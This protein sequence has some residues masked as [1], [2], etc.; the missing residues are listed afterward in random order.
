MAKL[1]IDTM[2]D[3][4]EI[5]HYDTPGIPLYIRKGNL[6]DYPGRR[7]PCHWH[8]DI[9][10]ILLLDGEMNYYVNGENIELG[11]GEGIFVNSRVM[12]Y[13]YAARNENCSFLC[14]LFH[15]SLL[16]S[17]KQVFQ[18]YVEPIL[19]ETRVSYLYISGQGQEEMENQILN[20]WK[21]KEMQ[22]PCYEM[23]VIGALYS[24]WHSVSSMITQMT[25]S[26]EGEPSADVT[27]LRQMVSFIRLNFREEIS[28]QDIA[29]EA[30]ICKSKCCKIFKAQIAQSPIDYL[31]SYRLH[32]SAD[33]LKHTSM[34][35]SDVALECGFNH[36][37]YYSKLFSRSYGCTPR[38]YR[39]GKMT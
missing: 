24:L 35:V 36:L 33:L 15:P 19:E 16:A 14:I 9:E 17:C 26:P 31:N 10:L 18:R 6:F 7:A 29:D 2:P 20:I 5:I 25:G 37:S 11:T 23:D 12:H 4:Y 13:G 21:L 38:E 8:D 30:N 32:I 3:Q 28:L 1:R 27:A 39:R 22:T 34:T